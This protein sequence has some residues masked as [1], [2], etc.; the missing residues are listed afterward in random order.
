MTA[1]RALQ[2]FLW[3]LAVVFVG[4]ALRPLRE[5]APADAASFYI[6]GHLAATG[7]AHRLYDPVANI[8]SWDAL[9]P[10]G[11]RREET[12]HD[13]F[14]IRPAFVAYLYAP[15]T[16]LSFEA[17]WKLILGLTFLEVLLIVWL[18]PRWFRDYGDLRPWRPLLLAYL[19][20]VWAMGLTQDTVSLTLV[21][22]FALHMILKDRQWLG[23]AV[24]ALLVIKPHLALTLPIA[25]YFGGKRRAALA[26]TL[27]AIGLACVSF[28]LIGVQGVEQWRELLA[29]SRTDMFPHTMH[30]VRAFWIR[31]GAIPAVALLGIVVAAAFVAFRHGDF[32]T[33]VVV[34]ILAS[35]LLSPHTYTQ[36]LALLA[37]IPFLTPWA[38]VR[39]AAFF[40]WMYVEPFRSDRNWPVVALAAAY[41]VSLAW[42]ALPALRS[43]PSVM[44]NPGSVSDG[45]E[46]SY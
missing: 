24:A 35:L 5:G 17:A 38:V 2:A 33:K 40:P 44:V 20:F 11:L 3:L 27:G 6:G 4:L 39:W 32:E 7:Q 14:F 42:K 34:G 8:E 30:N 25:F 15:F 41:L 26:F 1:N 37:L 9:R 12:P 45:R 16:L 43:A 22:G 29:S 31:F 10:M 19:P 21:L 18:F 23:G 13:N 46:G 36:D 28:A